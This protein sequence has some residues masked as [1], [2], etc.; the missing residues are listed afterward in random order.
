MQII[1]R[2]RESNATPADDEV[3]IEP[4]GE[5]PKDN[6][7][8][9]LACDKSVAAFPHGAGE[10]RKLV[11]DCDPTLDDMVAALF[12]EERLSGR[13][14]AKGAKSFA[15]YTRRRREGRMPSSLPLEASIEG[16]YLAIR[17][18]GDGD[19]TKPATAARFL[20]D[21][22][23]MADVILKAAAADK[24]PFSEP[25]F[26]DG[27]A[28]ADER[29]SLA[30][31]RAV[32]HQDVLR[33]E[34]WIVDIPGA[35]NRSRAL[36]LR[37]PTSLLF[38]QWSRREGDCGAE[39]PFVFL[40]VDWGKGYWMFST[41]PE[42]RLRLSTLADALQQAEVQTDAAAAAHKPW[43]RQYGDTLVSHRHT[44]MPDEKVLS[45]VKHW[46]HARR[47]P[48]A[49]PI[50]AWVALA[51]VLLFGVVSWAVGLSGGTR[52][53][54]ASL[55]EQTAV[56]KSLPVDSNGSDAKLRTT[57]KNVQNSIYLVMAQDRNGNTEAEGTAWVLNKEKGILVTNGHVAEFDD[58]AKATG[59]RLILRS[60]GNQ[61]GDVVV[62]GTKLHPGFLD[63]RK[64]WQQ[65]IGHSPAGAAQAEPPVNF[66][67]VALL[68]VD[69]PESLAPA[70]TLADDATLLHLGKPDL[71]G[72]I[73]YLID[74]EANPG[75][76]PLSPDP[77]AETGDIAAM[78]DYFGDPS[79]GDPA[80]QLLIQHNISTSGGA[81]GSPILNAD[82][83]VIGVHSAGNYILIP[84][85]SGRIPAG[86]HYAQRADLVKELLESDDLARQAQQPRTDRWT[87]AL[88]NNKDAAL[89]LQLF[90]EWKASIDK[91][92]SVGTATAPV[93]T[94]DP[95]S[96]VAKLSDR[97]PAGPASKLQ[98]YRSTLSFSVDG[99]GELI[100]A[101][102]TA[103]SAPL[104]MTVYPVVNGAR[105]S[106]LTVIAFGD[107]QNHPC[108]QADVDGPQT[109]EVELDADTDLEYSLRASLA[110]LS[111]QQKRDMLAA[112]WIAKHAAWSAA[113]VQPR[114]VL[115]VPGQTVENS[116][117][118]LSTTDIDHLTGDSKAEAEFFA[119]ANSS[120]GESLQLEITTG[121][122]TPANSPASLDS[123]SAWPSQAFTDKL[124]TSVRLTV[125]GPAAGIKYDVVIYTAG[126]KPAAK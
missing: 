67:D 96:V 38:P 77:S 37:Q 109:F 30:A 46:A 89:F 15:H 87:A 113:H 124:D 58:K 21:W 24:N 111:T 75:L 78:T 76:N 82:G 9:E 114:V 14:L 66:C 54:Q 25:L 84:G 10:I 47:P 34:Q 31:D 18:A 106:P 3:L 98:D 104:R 118:F 59:G 61:Q 23:R 51:A 49:K 28:F 91:Q 97:Q 107:H 103:T 43:K 95:I 8:A 94:V 6:A 39:R 85:W 73:G 57:L 121:G 41:D 45:V 101:A 60:R 1:F 110:R 16:I 81:S 22:R 12:V 35:P 53:R 52:V 112:A 56:A 105:R 83:N 93:A 70:L 40:A 108:A 7:L 72:F 55:Q 99:S 74:N 42:Q 11:V 63:W 88:S 79:I 33:G 64:L 13:E 100:V 62:I 86:L 27:D 119:V 120:N 50:P 116:G 44:N 48:S 17:N 26:S 126:L 122:A 69:Q 36:F 115:D 68:Y 71:I 2:K 65:G 5:G 125:V 29:A 117:R 102:Y 92:A 19:L 80:Q 4:R 20:D 123:M 90:G 32:F